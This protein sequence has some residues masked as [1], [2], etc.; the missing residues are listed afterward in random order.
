MNVRGIEW[1]RV[2]AQ[3]R[4]K[5]FLYFIEIDYEWIIWTKMKDNY[6]HN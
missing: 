2:R 5:I 4:N 6:Y 1:T 3:E